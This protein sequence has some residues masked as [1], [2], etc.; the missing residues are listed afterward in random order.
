MSSAPSS[1]NEVLAAYVAG[2]EKAAR[3]VAVVAEAYYR[4][5][6]KGKGEGLEPVIAVIERAAPGMVELVGSPGRPG[7]EIRLAQREFPKG[8]EAELKQ[9]VQ[10]VLSGSA[11]RRTVDVNAPGISDN[12]ERKTSLVARVFAAVRRLFTASA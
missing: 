12:R 1:I 9:A 11:R 3:V 10:V 8:Y 4:D 2:R 7:F 5:R 6:G